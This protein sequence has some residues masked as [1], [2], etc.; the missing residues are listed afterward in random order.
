F[1]E[2]RIN[3]N[4][5]RKIENDDLSGFPST[6]YAK[7]FLKQYGSFLDVDVSKAIE[8]L[9]RGEIEILDKPAV[10]TMVS[11]VKQK[12]ERTGSFRPGKVRRVRRNK[13]EKPGGAPV[14][15]GVIL[16]V[17]VVAIGVFFVLGYRADSSKEFK[18]NVNGTVAEITSGS[19]SGKEEKK[20]A[21]VIPQIEKNPLARKNSEEKET[22][23]ENKEEGNTS[24]SPKPVPV[25]SIET[26]TP[27][28]KAETPPTRTGE[29]PN[30]D[31]DKSPTTIG[32]VRIKVPSSPNTSIGDKPAVLRP[33]GTDP[34]AKRPEQRILKAI[35]VPEAVVANG[36][37]N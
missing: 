31:F 29:L 5:I 22:S 9:D 7:S 32:K 36:A 37:G 14:F 35:P 18:E 30:V 8:S 26:E 17:L 1:H 19:I 33:T 24:A 20:P 15:L 27:V 21:T 4:V 2:T 34:V 12:I 16:V 25:S 3:A 6:G 13:V 11:G 23:P 10:D 28:S